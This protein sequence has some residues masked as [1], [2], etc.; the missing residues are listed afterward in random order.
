MEAG[1]G[2]PRPLSEYLRS[3]PKGMLSANQLLNK[4]KANTGARRGGIPG[5]TSDFRYSDIT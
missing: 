5:K 3:L 1:G 2:N 4:I